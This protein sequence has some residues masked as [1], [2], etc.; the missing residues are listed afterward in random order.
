VELTERFPDMWIRTI[1]SEWVLTKDGDNH[2]LD[3][4]G[5]RVVDEVYEYP[6]GLFPLLFEPQKEYPLPNGET[7]IL[8]RRTIGQTYLPEP[9]EALQPLGDS[10]K[11]W[12]HEDT[13]LLLSQADQGVD[14]GL[15]DLTPH[16]VRVM[17]EGLPEAD[18]V[19]VLLH[20]GEPSDADTWET[21][22]QEYVLAWD[23]W[24]DS[25]YL[26]IWG[27]ASTPTLQT[28]PDIQFGESVLTNVD[29]SDTV[30]AGHVLPITTRW[31]V[32]ATPLKA[33]YRLMNG[34]G[35]VIAQL[36]RDITPESRLG[37]FVP[38]ATPAGQ[39]TVAVT[40]YDPAT[41][42]PVLLDN[43]DSVATLFEVEVQASI[44][45]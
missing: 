19:F 44:E 14:L 23:G 20:R 28:E 37:L 12:L 39:Y 33:S 30:T 21:L 43:G 4:P 11:N 34:N 5:L 31:Q 24:F 8:W 17:D 27:R 42:A 36:D 7:A 18:T 2:D 35:E 29:G 41:V 6:E 38:P 40:V 45:N 13:P 25:E 15:L 26:T 3:E 1:R 9:K 10:L 32:G 16:H 22:Q